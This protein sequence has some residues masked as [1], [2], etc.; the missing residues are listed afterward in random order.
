MNLIDGEPVLVWQGYRNVVPSIANWNEPDRCLDFGDGWPK[1]TGDGDLIIP[2]RYA[3]LAGEMAEL[4]K[5]S[6]PIV[7]ED[8]QMMSALTRHAP[9][10]P[11]SQA[12]HNATESLSEILLPKIDALLAKLNPKQPD[13]A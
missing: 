10:D 6:R 4:L 3:K 12:L 1:R 11:Q 2:L 7:A 5:H 8:V 9:L 13:H